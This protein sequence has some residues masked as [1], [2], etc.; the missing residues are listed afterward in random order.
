MTQHQTRMFKSVLTLTELGGGGG[1]EQQYVYIN[2][3]SSA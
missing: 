1:E 2:S 3:L